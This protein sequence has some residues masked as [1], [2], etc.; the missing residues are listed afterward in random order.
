MNNPF[1][2]FFDWLLFNLKLNYLQI[3]RELETAGIVN[4]DV[5]RSVVTLFV[6]QEEENELDQVEASKEVNKVEDSFSTEVVKD[7]DNKLKATEREIAEDLQPTPQKDEPGEKLEDV[8]QV[9]PDETEIETS[10]GNATSVT[11]M[12]GEGT[13][14]DIAETSKTEN[15]E[16]TQKNSDDAN[17]SGKE[18]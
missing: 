4:E 3:P 14:Q 5:E 10:S 1:R 11:C 12:E 8:L 2:K 9:A 16:E 15:K 17:V 18:V 7:D 6:K 13:I